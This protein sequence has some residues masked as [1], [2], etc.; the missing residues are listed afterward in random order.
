[1]RDFQKELKQAAANGVIPEPIRRLHGLNRIDAILLDDKSDVL[2]AGDHNPSF[3]AIEIDDLLVALRSA[4]GAGPDYKGSPGCTIDPTPGAANPWQVQL[5]KVFGMP[6]GA[7]MGQRH[8]RID[9]ELKKVSAGLMDLSPSIPAMFESSRESAPCRTNMDA[10][11]PASA[12]HRFWFTPLYPEKPRFL[13]DDTGVFIDKPVKVQ[14]QSEEEFLRDGRRVGSAP[15]QPA[16]VRFTEAVTRA[17]DTDEITD[18]THLRND[19]RLIEA[20]VLMAHIGVNHEV[21]GYLLGECPL[22]LARP[23]ERVSG[24]MRRESGEAACGSALTPGP[25][26]STLLTRYQ[27]EFRGGVEARV[28]VTAAD[29]VRDAAQELSR[30]RR[31]IRDGAPGSPLRTFA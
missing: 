16:A 9:Y 28:A 23:V 2:L 11:A 10:R 21:L 3:P 27:Q 8:V 25:K 18:Y 30:L 7:P 1:L 13:Q 31:R 4:F 14:L 5:V 20:A 17:L 24:I 22:Q 29:F 19:F 26:I 6:A 15:S 12:T